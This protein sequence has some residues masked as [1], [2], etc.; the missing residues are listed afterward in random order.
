MFS[1]PSLGLFSFPSAASITFKTDKV[2]GLAR[3]Y[4]EHVPTSDQRYYASILCH[5]NSAPHLFDTFSIKDAR[6][7]RDKQPKNLKSFIILLVAHLESL[8]SDD[9]FAV[10]NQATQGLTGLGRWVA[11]PLSPLSAAFGASDGSRT[12]RA[13]PRDRTKEALNCAR[14]LTRLLPVLMECEPHAS[15]SQSTFASPLEEDVLWTRRPPTGS[16]AQSTSAATSTPFA[17]PLQ[18]LDEHAS[19]GE[20]TEDQFVIDDDEDKVPLSA[21]GNFKADALKK[22]AAKSTADEKQ[23]SEESKYLTLAE[24]LIGLCVEFLF[25]PGFTLPLLGDQD[26][27]GSSDG[28]RVHYAIWEKGIGASVGLE[29]VTQQH[30]S[31]RIDFVRLLLVLMSK[32]TYVPPSAQNDFQ[33]RALEYICTSLCRKTTLS[34][35]CSLLNTAC[36][37]GFGGGWNVPI[38]GGNQ[39]DA[40]SNR[41]SLRALTLQ[42]L[43][44]I[45]EWQPKGSK[46]AAAALDASSESGLVRPQPDRTISAASTLPGGGLSSSV[47]M[48]QFG[49]WLSKLHRAADLDMLSSSLLAL[50]RPAVNSLLSLPIP[51]SVGVAGL[52]TLQ[53]IY[54]NSAE[55]MTLLWRL[56]RSNAK[57]KLFVLDDGVRAPVLLSTLLG[58]ALLGKDSSTSHGIVRLALFIL[59]DVSACSSFVGHICKIGSANKCKLPSRF[60]ALINGASSAADVLISA[61]YTLLTTRGMG[62]SGL[63]IYPVILITLANC[64]AQLKSMTISSATR[65]GLLL[66]Q[67]SNPSFL[68]ADEGHPRCLY[69]LLET[70]N[71]VLMHQAQSNYNLVYTVL[72]KE[73]EVSRLRKITLRR[74]L[75]EIRKRSGITQA[76][77]APSSSQASSNV[78]GPALARSARAAEGD[79]NL[80]GQSNGNSADER[81]GSRLKDEAT[82]SDGNDN[83][84]PKAPSGKA[85]GKVRAAN[86]PELPPPSSASQLEFEVAANEIVDDFDNDEWVSKLDD[87]ELYAAAAQI[88][89]NGFVAMDDWVT[90][91]ASN[92][93]LQP[94]LTLHNA[95]LPEIDVLCSSEAVVNR[96]DADQR[97]LAWLREKDLGAI[98][99]PDGPEADATV[100]QALVRPFRW[101]EQVTIWLLSY[102]WG[103]IYVKHLRYALWLPE[104]IKLFHLVLQSQQ[105]MAATEKQ[106]ST[107]TIASALNP[108]GVFTSAFGALGF[109]GVG[110]GIGGVAGA[111]SGEEQRFPRS[112]VQA[113]V[114][115]GE[116]SSETI[117]LAVGR[118]DGSIV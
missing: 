85:L 73:R 41:E 83:A 35:L 5:F 64:S 53:G 2:N 42:L 29:G 44:I 55:A 45:L 11:A 68:L 102:I 86:S 78:N 20:Q 81:S 57:F 14:L 92:L 19:P 98:F 93:P 111:A 91:W 8:K 89:R 49:Y 52:S 105:K 18:P 12:S 75:A 99:R 118:Q 70:I 54:L 90:S 6:A 33:D 80:A 26:Q 46:V 112:A 38:F 37:P 48:N 65:L 106:A 21:P 110:A 16:K 107:T 114:L 71:G 23:K 101:T 7:I 27:Q 61:S 69:F 39:S 72:G 4:S 116:S 66:T 36:S 3:L 100:S 50:L 59:Q 113:S 60:S 117:R 15:S 10:P 115:D 109:G 88:G 43:V 84:R 77:A 62:S 13:L 30:V 97:V 104:G 87:G 25:F 51:A 76:A 31:N 96:S 32:S 95:L 82:R 28:S 67:F 63:G 94:L 79:I 56:L 9:Q 22:T 24:H 1:L 103:G 17:C 40:D 108:F 74:A 34:L 47:G 58:H